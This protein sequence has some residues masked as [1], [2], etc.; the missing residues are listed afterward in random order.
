MIRKLL[1]A[2]R[3]AA[4]WLAPFKDEPSFD[5]L[6]YEQ[7]QDR[8]RRLWLIDNRRESLAKQI[9]AARKAKKARKHLYA[10]MERLTT[11]KLRLERG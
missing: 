11:E 9:A 10:E 7:S 8:S 4:D 3:T 2:I 6:A 5:R 1:T